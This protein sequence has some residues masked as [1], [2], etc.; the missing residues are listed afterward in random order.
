MAQREVIQQ[1]KLQLAA[2]RNKKSVSPVQDVRKTQEDVKP[3]L[4]EPSFTKNS[5]IRYSGYEQPPAAEPQ[6]DL[7]AAPE[8]NLYPNPYRLTKSL[9]FQKAQSP[10]AHPQPEQI[11]KR[12]GAIISFTPTKKSLDDV[13]EGRWAAEKDLQSGQQRR[14]ASSRRTK[15]SRVYAPVDGYTPSG[16]TSKDIYSLEEIGSQIR[17]NPRD[18]R[19]DETDEYIYSLDES[20]QQHLG[21]TP[22]RR[23]A[24]R[25]PKNGSQPPSRNSAELKKS[26]EKTKSPT[27][28]ELKLTKTT[29]PFQESAAQQGSQKTTV[30]T[31]VQHTKAAREP[32]PVLN[33]SKATDLE[34]SYSTKHH[35]KKSGT[36][37]V[38]SAYSMN[39]LA[40]PK[41]HTHDEDYW[42]IK[43]KIKQTEA[44]YKLPNSPESK[45]LQ[46]SLSTDPRLQSR[47]FEKEEVR[48][49]SKGHRAKETGSRE[50]EQYRIQQLEV[51]KALRSKRASSSQ[52]TI[53]G[54]GYDKPL[55][56]TRQ[57]RLEHENIERRKS[58]KLPIT[59]SSTESHREEIKQKAAPRKRNPKPAEIIEP[60]VAPPKKYLPA[61]HSPPTTKSVIS[62]RTE[63]SAKIAK[64]EKPKPVRVARKP[65][66]AIPQ[67]KQ[68]APQP[69]L[70]AESRKSR[71]RPEK[72]PSQPPKKLNKTMDS[73]KSE[74]SQ[75]RSASRRER[76]KAIKEKERLLEIQQREF[77]ELERKKREILAKKRELQE[78]EKRMAA[79]RPDEDISET[80]HQEM[81]PDHSR[82]DSEPRT[83]KEPEPERSPLP[84]IVEDS[85]SD[86]VPPQTNPKANRKSPSRKSPSSSGTKAPTQKPTPAPK[87][88]S[89]SPK[90]APAA[91][92]QPEDPAEP[93][94]PPNWRKPAVPQFSTHTVRK[95]PKPQ[96]TPEP[97]A[98]PVVPVRKPA[99]P[100]EA[101]P[102]KKTRKPLGDRHAPVDPSLSKDSKDGRD[103][104]DKDTKDKEADGSALRESVHERLY[105]SIPVQLQ[106]PSFKQLEREVSRSPN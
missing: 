93:K 17:D 57:K 84:P 73:N 74:D 42:Q 95:S 2:I 90:P 33:V 47:H 14:T 13:V 46:A 44:A 32:S 5:P 103:T 55:P 27:G 100:A 98:L 28:M 87:P 22:D 21:A 71:E 86:T 7:N 24:Q 77:A 52:P 97:T 18:Y 105:R 23:S 19:Q 82:E 96:P 81:Q 29:A 51:L 92:V 10:P 50:S 67:K 3:K 59:A 4:L 53:L 89:R 41:R 80:S 62:L 75:T 12:S 16:D 85:A 65:V 31:A 58:E 1:A 102:K 15:E 66:E 60:V 39:N 54:P 70:R 9:A 64:E 99:L 37:P 69:K 68:E 101:V 40:K 106:V 36:H 79:I 104:K 78:Q 56:V 45:L 20:G 76:I 35:T 30:P 26:E 72:T 8:Y 11:D 63:D 43:Q 48:E 6:K 91:A 83:K 34:S 38:Q 94:S 25:S 61:I 88:K 49:L